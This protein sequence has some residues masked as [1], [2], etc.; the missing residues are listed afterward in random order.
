[1]S[2]VWP[3]G[4]LVVLLLV[5]TS[6][7]LFIW[8]PRHHVPDDAE[9]KVNYY[10]DWCDHHPKGL[11]LFHERC[12]GLCW[13]IRHTV[14]GS[15]SFSFPRMVFGGLNLL[16][17]LVVGGS[18]VLV[19]FLAD[20]DSIPWRDIGIVTAIIIACWLYRLI[21]SGILQRMTQQSNIRKH[22][23]NLA[24]ELAGVIALTN[25][26]PGTQDAAKL[27]AA[28]EDILRCMRY[29]AQIMT[30]DLEGHC[31][32]VSLLLFA[33]GDCRH[34]RVED[35]A[36]PRRDAGTTVAVDEILCYYAARLGRY[37]SVN[38]L[39]RHTPFPYKGISD[40]RPKY[41]SI[42][43]IPVIDIEDGHKNCPGIVTIDSS[44]PFGFWLIGSELV[45]RMNPYI[46]WLKLLLKDHRDRLQ[47][48][49]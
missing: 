20:N 9:E 19:K 38:D 28:R 41:R 29:R 46:S 30:D 18:A 49:N 44:R 2:F 1:M 22:E 21:Y 4:I 15:V 27:K 11:A 36:T 23:N 17:L 35:R 37:I 34:L 6:M 45:T 40:S 43:A 31:V 26:K 3:I 5:A 48:K 7:W 33:D 42:M 47:V 32:E 39:K 12:L 13:R 8:R 16:A 14:F 10:L 25:L 24:V